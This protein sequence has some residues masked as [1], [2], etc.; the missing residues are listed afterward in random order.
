[1]LDSY[2]G[3]P[4]FRFE[5]QRLNRTRTGAPVLEEKLRKL[6]PVWRWLC[7]R[8]AR[9][10]LFHA[11]LLAQGSGLA[12]E[13]I[14]RN[15]AEGATNFGWIVDAVMLRMPDV[16]GTRDRFVATRTVVRRLID[17]MLGSREKVVIVSCPAGTGRDVLEATAACRDPGA[18]E[19]R[20]LDIDAAALA[21]AEELARTL[22][23]A[24]V[25]TQEADIWNLP[26]GFAGLGDIVV[27]EGFVDYFEADADV[28]RLYRDHLG[29]LAAPG[30]VMVT[31]CAVRI[32]SLYFREAI[33]DWSFVPRKESRFR[34]ILRRAGFECRT[35]R[36]VAFS[37]QRVFVCRKDG[38]T[39]R[40]SSPE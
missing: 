13:L 24:N 10:A 16:V 29:P 22:G 32:L 38:E 14:Y 2:F 12:M 40:S 25:E 15:R 28:E 36:G 7:R 35:P 37:T 31:S 1:M 8:L 9:G 26:G 19:I 34:E 4:R 27:S 21:Y 17:R 23:V 5:L 30:G 39:G 33:L 3:N 18:V 20:L 6:N 11:T